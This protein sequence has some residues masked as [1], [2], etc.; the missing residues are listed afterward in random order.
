MNGASDIDWWRMLAGYLLLGLPLVI[1]NASG[2]NLVRSV[3]IGTVRMTLQLL[4]V[5]YYLKVIFFWNNSS[6][7]LAWLFIMIVIAGGSVTGRSGL[8]Y[9]KALLPVIVSLIAG[10][11]L[12]SG[13]ILGVVIALPDLSDARHVIPVSGMIIGN[14]L[15]HSIVGLRT[16]YSEIEKQSEI[17]RYYLAY[18]ASRNEAVFSFRAE[19]MKTAVSPSVATLSNMG[20]VS[21]PGMMTG[22]IL[23]GS[24]PVTAVKY[25]ILIM[26]AIHSATVTGLYFS[27]WFTSLYLF[28][29]Y[30]NLRK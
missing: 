10:V 9:R 2:V 14:M 13:Y 29:K 23:G 4:L 18:G 22:Q 3:L 17:F 15:N 7:N 16:F 11:G 27:I 8:P 20:L 21:L 1:L 5:G 24:D 28:D 30:D 26:I 6:V 19:A 25:Q 12:T